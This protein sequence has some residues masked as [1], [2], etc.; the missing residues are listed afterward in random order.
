MRLTYGKAL[1][2][3]LA[4][5][6]IFHG[7][8]GADAFESLE[9]RRGALG[10]MHVE[11]FAAH[12]SPASG[13]DQR[14]LHPIVQAVESAI[15]IGLQDTAEGLQMVSGPPTQTTTPSHPQSFDERATGSAPVGERAAFEVHAIAGID[16]A[17]AVK[18]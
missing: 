4:P 7:I 1:I 2:G 3:Q 6:L 9:R 12:V 17:L 11:E 16:L 15:R 13:L 5:D 8:Q 14:V 18:R 10:L